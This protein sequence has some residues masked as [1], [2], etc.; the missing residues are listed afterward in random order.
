MKLRQA[1]K[2]FR[3]P[4]EGHN[5]RTT[6]RAARR[7]RLYQGLGFNGQGLY[8][9]KPKRA[10]DALHALRVQRWLNYREIHNA[11][12]AASTGSSRGSA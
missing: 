5:H 2:V 3:D 8:A 9:V 4:L 1:R 10:R 6:E 12:E 11:I 7:L